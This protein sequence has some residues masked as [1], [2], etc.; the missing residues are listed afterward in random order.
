M[1]FSSFQY[2]GF[3]IVTL[4]LLSILRRSEHKK[5]MLL[6]G[7]YYFYACWDWRFTALLVALSGLNYFAGA[8]I[9]ANLGEIRKKWLTAAVTMDLAILGVFKY[10]GFFVSNLNALLARAHTS[11]PMAHIILP[12]GISFITFEVISYVVDV[13]KGASPPA[14][15]ILDFS[16]LVA[17][18]PHL[19]A[20]P[21]LK[22]R[23]FLPE[24]ETD[25]CVRW[26]NIE[27][28]AFL[29][30][31]GLMKKVL[32]A[33][34]VAPFV[35]MTFQHARYY[36]TGT[37]WL[38]VIAYSLQIFCDFS[39]YSDMAIGS[40]ICMG[41]EIPPNFNMPYISTSITEFW[42]R[43]HI[44][45]S[46]WLRDYLYIPLGG[47][48]RGRP[49]QFANLFIT[50]LLGGL[51]HGASWNFVIWGGMHGAGLAVHK[52][53]S[54][55]I[56]SR[57]K[58]AEGLLKALGWLATTT[59]VCLLWVA[60]RSA[61]SAQAWAV[62]QR[63]FAINGAGG[64]A[65]YQ[66]QLLIALPFAVLAHYMGTRMAKGYSPKI[67]TFSGSFAFSFGV[68]ALVFLSPQNSSPFIYFQF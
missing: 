55:Q 41:L 57:L 46:T 39:G 67:T 10:Y 36:N 68:L 43:W 38:S 8:R 49:R 16:L 19:I 51:W 26:P 13:Y 11:L 1:I 23:Q 14:K 27:R 30:L 62:Y 25:I 45:L 15:S 34:N 9:H 48:R 56:G 6:I 59:F 33:D 2:V 18:F 63:L 35:D 12:V 47:N 58:G 20:G 4:I 60:F 64:I 32:I 31:F 7:S 5:L 37:M 28:G 40:A 61:T 65:W 52:L 17:F 54:E 53:Y 44:S 22:P 29:F 66:A 42:R 50:M 24:I 3:L 21:I